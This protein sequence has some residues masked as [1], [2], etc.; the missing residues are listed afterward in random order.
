MR[1]ATWNVNS[2]RVRVG[3]LTSFLL[4]EQDDSPPIDVILLQEIKCMTEAFPREIFEDLGYNCLVF[5]QKSNNGVAILSKYRIE[6]ERFGDGIFTDDPSAR[7]VDALINGHRVASVYVPNGQSPESPQYQYKLRF[8]DILKEHLAHSIKNEKFIIG[9][10]FNITRSDID[11]YDT[12]LWNSKRI[13]C[14]IP[15]RD[16]LAEILEI[17]FADKHRE[18]AGGASIY[19]WWDYRSSS[20]AKNNGLRLDYML[21]THD[22]NVRACAVDQYTRGLERPSDHAPVVIDIA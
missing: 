1:I 14:T 13:S 8:L 21:T 11:V 10:D 17:G 4:G 20:F 7:Y 19:T 9:G 3:Q 12:G 2:V 5:G 18:F 22:V 6:D 15:E 16:R